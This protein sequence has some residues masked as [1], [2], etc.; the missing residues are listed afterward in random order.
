M[1]NIPILNVS[2]QS[3]PEAWEKALLAVWE[4]G[5]DVETEY[6]RP[7]DSPSRDATVIVEVRDPFSEPRIHKNFP[8]GPQ[9][10]EIYRQEVVEGIHDH[11]IDPTAGKWTYT[12]SDR[13]FNY[14]VSDELKNPNGARPFAPV[15]QIEY[16]IEKLV[17]QPFSRRAQA[18]TW[19]PTT[20]PKTDDSPCLQRVWAR[21]LPDEG[22]R[23]GGSTDPAGGELVLS[24]NA[25][26]RSRDL[27]KAWFM[28]VYALTDLQ[29][30][31][32]EEV[33]RRLV[34]KVKVGRYVDISDSLHLYGAYFD[35]IE[36]ELRK[37]KADPDYT[38]RAWRSDYSAFARMVEETRER[39]KENPDFMVESSM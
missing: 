38:K 29:R 3:L 5:V 31:I 14:T 33:S 15:N 11:W 8:G 35:E 19:M 4:Q 13:L 9:E 34:R 28:N 16:L 12:Y 10:L 21:I 17:E 1:G 23:P 24:L 7:E 37:M 22:L 26:W 36:P 18:I 27:Y 6:D 2:G 39:L 20:D 30:I 32:A 25:H